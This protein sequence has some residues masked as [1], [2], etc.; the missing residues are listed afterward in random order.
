MNGRL[1]G[2][3]QSDV[4]TWCDGRVSTTADS[5][6]GEMVDV[7]GGIKIFW[8][9]WGASDGVPAV[10][11][12]GGPGGGLRTSQYRDRFDLAR[13]RL[14]GLDQRGCG[15]STPHA[16]DQAV[17]LATN[18][19]AHLIADLEL[20][21][22][23]LGIQAW[24]VNGA[25]W[26]STLALAY[27]Q[28]HPQR[29][30]GIVLYAATTTSR[31]EVDWVTEGMG[32]VFPEAWDRF[33]SHAEDAGIGYR[34]RRDRL[35]EAYAR[36]MES[37]DPAVRDAASREW[38]LWEDTHISIGAGGFRRDPRWQDRPFRH[39]FVRLTTHYWA[40]DG[41]CD[42]PI[43][44]QMDRLHGIPGVIIHGRRDISCPAAT[45]WEL[46]RRWPG[47]S[48]IIDEGDGHGGTSMAEAWLAANNEM[49]TGVGS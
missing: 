3:A 40:H 13:T 11:L 26:G 14:I 23:H 29:V 25:S 18:T 49:V 46:H 24:I 21:R 4:L 6:S 32:A 2:T 17:S 43:L 41:F 39:A 34:R 36:L 12:H 38:A 31:R 7:G 16:A 19:T 47:S 30:L 9:Q 20:L 48:L 8:E 10:Y 1:L 15:R 44:K 5:G 22:K 45:A 37:P 28:M 42:P 27:T 33:A 35:V